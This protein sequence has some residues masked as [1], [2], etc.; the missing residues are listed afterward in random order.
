MQ[1]SQQR[2]K[3]T[4]AKTTVKRKKQENKTPFQQWFAGTNLYSHI[5]YAWV[6]G[7][8][9]GKWFVGHNYSTFQCVLFFILLL[10]L[11]ILLLGLHMFIGFF[12]V[13]SFIISR[14]RSIDIF[15]EPTWAK[16]FVDVPFRMVIINSIF[17]H[18]ERE[19]GREKDN[20]HDIRT[21]A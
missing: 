6:L 3:N 18:R 10:L 7:N 1:R 21:I 13:H 8:V 17:A 19:R 20:R 5:S 4:I 12:F 15:S 11:L 2:K 14:I 16:W 9:F